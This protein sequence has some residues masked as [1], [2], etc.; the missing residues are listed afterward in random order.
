MIFE[1]F[2]RRPF[3]ISRVNPR[4]GIVDIKKPLTQ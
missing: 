4:V 3:A 2:I 1:P